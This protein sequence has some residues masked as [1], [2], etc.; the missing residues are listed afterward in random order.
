[1]WIAR[2]GKWGLI[3]IITSRDEWWGLLE[4]QWPQLQEIVYNFLDYK[5]M[6][7]IDP[8]DASSASTGRTISEEMAHLKATRDVKVARYLAY[9]WGAA[10]DAY[11]RES[12]PGWNALCDLLSE[13]QIAHDFEPEND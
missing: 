7:Y 8:G 10:S 12:V 2:T 6:A 5:A 4:R 9:A 1:L 13:E 11:A 3:L